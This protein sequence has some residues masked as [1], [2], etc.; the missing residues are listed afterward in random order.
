MVTTSDIKILKGHSDI[1]K[2]PFTAM[3]QQLYHA[4]TLADFTKDSFIKLRT[5][6]LDSD[7]FSLV[8]KSDVYVQ[9]TLQQVIS[10]SC[11][12]ELVELLE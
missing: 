4:I 8:N 9:K 12:K 10:D 1:D 11:S 5:R 7:E 3:I 2:Y 6:I